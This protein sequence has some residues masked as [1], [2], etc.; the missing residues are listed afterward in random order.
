[1]NDNPTADSRAI[2]DA[3][4]G[5]LVETMAMDQLQCDPANVRL[6]NQKNIDAI[7][8]S[9]KRFGQQK[10]IVIDAHGVIRAGNGTFQ[11]ARALGWTHI[12]VV[13]T[14]LV[15]ADAIAYGIADNRTAELA[16][17][18]EAALAQQLAGLDAEMQKATGFL[19]SE[20]SKLGEA[21]GMDGDSALPQ[22]YELAVTCEDQADQQALY[23]R[24]VAEGRTCR[25]LTL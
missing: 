19:P 20:L 6:H 22:S 3:T 2:A 17:W 7:K 12:S 15:S 9:L 25:V 23:D 21:P 16:T 14:K 4:D 10:P 18:D 8:Q 11:A 1:M 24:L 5:L 13:R